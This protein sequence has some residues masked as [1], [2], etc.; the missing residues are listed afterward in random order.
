MYT[1]TE[2]I[3]TNRR[4]FSVKELEEHFKVSRRCIYYWI[5]DFGL[6]VDYGRVLNNDRFKAF[7]NVRNQ[8]V[9]EKANARERRRI[10]MQALSGNE[11]V[12]SR[13]DRKY[14]SNTSLL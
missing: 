9:T 7:L 14:L 10:K 6:I 5:K 13:V 3:L 2:E 11:S 1:I 8:Y 12:E 4:S